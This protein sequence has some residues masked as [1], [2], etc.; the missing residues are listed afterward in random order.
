MAEDRALGTNLLSKYQRFSD[1]HSSPT[2]A[3]P[4]QWPSSV[5]TKWEDQPGAKL[6]R[7]LTEI[8]VG[9]LIQAELLHRDQIDWVRHEH[10]HAKATM[11]RCARS[12]AITAV[13]L[14]NG[15]RSSL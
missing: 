14:R 10:N 2:D 13:S 8:V 11:L 3:W 4:A 12:L 1:F 15:L 9:I 7:P 5:Q 6:E